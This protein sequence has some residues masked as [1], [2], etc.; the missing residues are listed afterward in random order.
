MATVT[1]QK[2]VVKQ[3]PKI[4][5]SHGKITAKTVIYRS[6]NMTD[7]NIIYKNVDDF[8]CSGSSALILSKNF[9]DLYA[10]PSSDFLYRNTVSFVF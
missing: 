8:I 9:S 5:V 1:L 3:F 7:G 2:G 4:Y 10:L 6:N